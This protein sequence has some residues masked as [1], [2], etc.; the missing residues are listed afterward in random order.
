[1]LFVGSVSAY[2]HVYAHAKCINIP[3]HAHI[4]FGGHFWLC[5]PK[6]W[7]LSS[8][9]QP[10]EADKWLS[11]PGYPY[12]ERQMWRTQKSGWAGWVDGWLSD[13]H[14]RAVW[15]I[16]IPYGGSQNSKAQ[17]TVY[18][19]WSPLNN[20]TGTLSTKCN[21]FGRGGCHFPLYISNPID[22]A[23][24]RRLACSVRAGKRCCSSFACGMC[25][26]SHFS[27]GQKV[28]VTGSGETFVTCSECM[29]LFEP[30]RRAT[31]SVA[32]LCGKPSRTLRHYFLPSS[33]RFGWWTIFR[34]AWRQF[35]AA[36]CSCLALSHPFKPKAF[37]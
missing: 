24:F 18:R 16:R 1:M 11:A 13:N 32:I 7:Y 26:T 29:A 6:R 15:S 25:T 36:S 9:P 2:A 17:I 10:F 3:T 23:I 20:T 31:I 21:R 5:S 28:A 8:R 4:L 35:W 33:V 37:I 22:A 14:T 19:V 12:D 27:A 34:V 30:K